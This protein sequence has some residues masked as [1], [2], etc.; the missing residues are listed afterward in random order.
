MNRDRKGFALVTGASSGTAPKLA[1]ALHHNLHST[2][3]ARCFPVASLG[4]HRR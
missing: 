3:R 4:A 1:T 2:V